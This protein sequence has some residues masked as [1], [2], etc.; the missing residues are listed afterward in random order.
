[1]FRRNISWV[2]ETIEMVFHS[3]GMIGEVNRNTERKRVRRNKRLIVVI[4][5]DQ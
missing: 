2:V 1:M 5:L 4:K 3:V